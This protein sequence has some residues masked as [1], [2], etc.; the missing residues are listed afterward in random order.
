LATSSATA[1]GADFVSSQRLQL[2]VCLSR[3]PERLKPRPRRFARVRERWLKGP[4]C[5]SSS[6]S[7]SQS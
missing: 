1:P 5:Q 6:S 4:G 3:T 2:L 7:A